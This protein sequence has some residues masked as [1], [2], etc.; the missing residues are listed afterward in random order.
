MAVTVYL[1]GG[2]LAVVE[3]A[4]TVED[5]YFIGEAGPRGAR[6]AAIQV[7]DDRGNLVGSFVHDQVIGYFIHSDGARENSQ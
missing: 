5:G 4:T 3:G 2:T 1:K 6:T 7:R